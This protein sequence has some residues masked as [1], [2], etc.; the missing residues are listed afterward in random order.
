MTDTIESVQPSAAYE[1][2][3][4]SI[5]G[6]KFAP[7]NDAR[8]APMASR[9]LPA[10]SRSIARMYG[11]SCAP[12]ARAAAA[13]QAAAHARRTAARRLRPVATVD[14]LEILDHR[15]SLFGSEPPQ[16]V[17]C[18]LAELHGVPSARLALGDDAVA[19]LRRLGFALAA[20]VALVLLE[21]PSR[22]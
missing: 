8:N 1:R 7:V 10:C 17:P 20:V 21:R 5:A 16:L 2:S 13:I 11:S 14:P 15:A 6:R 4:P 22:V 12:P 19:R 9:Y 18:G 3:S